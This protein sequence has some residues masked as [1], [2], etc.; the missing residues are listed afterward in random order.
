[1]SRRLPAILFLAAISC[2]EPPPPPKPPPTLQERIDA[3]KAKLQRL[4]EEQL[5][6]APTDARL[7]LWVAAFKGQDNLAG[8][9]ALPASPLQ[10]VVRC[11]W[12]PGD[13]AAIQAVDPSSSYG[14]LFKAYG[15]LLKA[16]GN[17]GYLREVAEAVEEA[18]KRKAWDCPVDALQAWAVEWLEKNEPDAAVR[19]CYRL[20]YVNQA[21]DLLLPFARIAEGLAYAPG[22]PKLDARR[23]A[24]VLRRLI[25]ERF[26]KSPSVVDVQLAQRVHP[27][28]L[29]AQF[30]LA[31]RQK[32]L[33]TARS[34]SLALEDWGRRDAALKAWSPTYQ[35][36]RGIEEAIT[37]LIQDGSLK[38][39]FPTPLKVQPAPDTPEQAAWRKEALKEIQAGAKAYGEARRAEGKA[40]FEEL[41]A[42][43]PPQSPKRNYLGNALRDRTFIFTDEYPK[44]R[45]AQLLDVAFD[46]DGL[47]D[48]QVAGLQPYA[49]T[50]RENL[51]RPKTI[52]SSLVAKRFGD[53]PKPNMDVYAVLRLRKEEVATA[54]PGLAEVRKDAAPATLHGYGLLLADVVKAKPADALEWL[55]E[56]EGPLPSGV[57]VM[58]A[59]TLRSATGKDFGPDWA[60]WKSFLETGN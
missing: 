43:R 14:P 55:P 17:P 15:I 37:G 35:S 47:N 1:M 53:R 2:G 5:A 60:R 36:R 48:G 38:P 56:V 8:I 29:E 19:A 10:A 45:H 28:V 26:L 31:W 34:A 6:A 51:I 50:V 33:D 42:R 4:A 25:E 23:P 32:D 22:I 9:Q 52:P 39:P 7:Q 41:E 27:I 58:I 57:E 54:R 18:L 40:I 24:D 16:R 30:L 3:S 13:E 46:G 59:D 44:D 49:W 21:R 12:S 11:S 20:R